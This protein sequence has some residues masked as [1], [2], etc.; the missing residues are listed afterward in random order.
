VLY[1]AASQK[2]LVQGVRK[3]QRTNPTRVTQETTIGKIRRPCSLSLSVSLSLCICVH[4]HTIDYSTPTCQIHI[5][6]GGRD[7]LLSWFSPAD[8]TQKVSY[9]QDLVSH[10]EVQLFSPRY[11]ETN[12]N[13]T[14]G[15]GTA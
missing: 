9:R 1:T 11:E 13:A 4:L 15:D 5:D 8:A 7:Q 3:S 10:R 14:P 12:W 2:S 6:K